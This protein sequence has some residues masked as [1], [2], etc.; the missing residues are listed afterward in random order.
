MSELACPRVPHPI[1]LES[2]AIMRARLDTADLPPLTRAVVER[3]VHTSAD[4]SWAGDLVCD[5]AAL[6][7]GRA[8]LLRR[9]PAG[10][11]RADGRGRDHV[12]ARATV[13]LDLPADAGGERRADPV[14]R[15][16][17]GRGAP[18]PGRGGVGDR[19]RADRAGR[20]AAAAPRPGWWTPR[21]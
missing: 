21:W 5:E 16:H 9:C 8:A 14:R 20:A 7:A 17:P 10:H 15:R 19:Q 4:P 3:V 18:V 11:R 2:Y 1:E 6:R 13:A 12:A